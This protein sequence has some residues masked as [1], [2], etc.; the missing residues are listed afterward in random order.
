M[1]MSAFTELHKTGTIP[2]RYRHAFLN[3][4]V[5]DLVKGGLENAVISTDALGAVTFHFEL[6]NLNNFEVVK[7]SLAKTIDSDCE[8]I[9][10]AGGNVLT[11]SYNYDSLELVPYYVGEKVIIS[12]DTTADP[13]VAIFSTAVITGITYNQADGEVKITTTYTFPDLTGSLVYENVKIEESVEEDENYG[14]FKILTAQMIASLVQG[15][16]S[17]PSQLD[18]ATF[19]TFQESVDLQ[20]YNRLIEI[21]PECVSLFIMFQN[22]E[23]TAT[24]ANKLSNNINVRSYRLRIDNQDTFD[25]DI[26]LNYE[27][28][29]LYTHD[30][31][32]YELLNRLFMNSS[33]PLKNFNCVALARNELLLP[34]VFNQAGNQILILGCPTPLTQKQKQVQINIECA[35]GQQVKNLIMYKLCLRSLKL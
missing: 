12:A 32:Y 15:P 25:R 6:D 29:N 24:N 31:A 22:P 16:V 4:P 17:I 21:E 28:N 7:Q 35:D 11:L 23:S 27:S 10:T 26:L 20:Y 19:T 1:L 14:T 5:S 8:D 34:N 9:P 2:S 13:P 33:L 3:I 30:P 18:Y